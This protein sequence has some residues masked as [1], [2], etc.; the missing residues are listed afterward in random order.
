MSVSERV[1]S[2]GKFQLYISIV[3][4]QKMW[5]YLDLIFQY[6]ETYG[7]ATYGPEYL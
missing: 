2:P 7:Y 4:T 3:H 5:T 1:S 6:H